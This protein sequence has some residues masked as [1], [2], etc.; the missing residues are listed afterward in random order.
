MH[1]TALNNAKL[2][3][4]TY[5]KNILSSNS[6]PHLVEIGSQDVNGSIREVCPI[7]FKYTGLDFVAAKGVD[8]ILDDPYTL[9]FENSS[10]D[11]VISSSC[12]EHSEMFWLVYLEVLRVLKPHGLFY[13]NAPSG[14]QVH[15]YPVDCWRF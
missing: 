6:D 3:F 9:P 4:E 14:G 11:V 1:P 5:A 15:R 7:F 2:F 10:V 12:F 8:I 13:L